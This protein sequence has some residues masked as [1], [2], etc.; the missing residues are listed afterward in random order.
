LAASWYASH[1]KILTPSTTPYDRDLVEVTEHV[2]RVL[3]ADVKT[4]VRLHR[5]L[6]TELKHYN[7]RHEE[8]DLLRQESLI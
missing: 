7:E 3:R 5:L 1:T 4:A 6:R 8:L 2:G